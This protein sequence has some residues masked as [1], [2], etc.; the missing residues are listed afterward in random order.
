MLPLG[1]IEG[2]KNNK[3]YRLIECRQDVG[4]DTLSTTNG[5]RYFI[6]SGFQN[7]LFII[8]YKSVIKRYN[9][10]RNWKVFKILLK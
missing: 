8:V 1:I 9:I 2:K 6:N 7:L 3:L 4:I 5:Y 10:L